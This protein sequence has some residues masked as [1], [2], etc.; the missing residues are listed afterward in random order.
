MIEDKGLGIQM[1]VMNDRPQGGSAYD[2]GRIELM[3]N[4]RVLSDDGM[5]LNEFLD[6]R[7]EHL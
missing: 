1:T 5:G 4:R 7:D 6:E 3:I 2:K